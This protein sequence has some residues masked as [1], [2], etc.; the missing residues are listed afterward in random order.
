MS[1][2]SSLIWV[3]SSTARQGF[4][5]AGAACAAAARRAALALQNRCADL[6]LHDPTLMLHLFD[7]LVRPVMLN[8]VEAWGP[9]ALCFDPELAGCEVVQRK[10][11]RC[12]LGVR[13]GTP[14]ASAL[15]ELAS[16]STGAHSG[17]A[18]VPLLEPAGGHAG[19]PAGQA[20]VLGERRADG[21]APTTSAQPAGLPRWTRSCPSC[22]PSLM[23]CRSTWTFARRCHEICGAEH[24]PHHTS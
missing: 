16:L 24:R 19:G 11:L 14:N 21:P 9:G 18:A 13:D 17:H 2:I 15:G 10:F 12:L 1:W 20:G 4:A 5:K 23:V 3:S 7:A 8:G 6:C 22:S